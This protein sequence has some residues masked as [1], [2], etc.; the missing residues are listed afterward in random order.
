MIIYG[1]FQ[2]IPYLKEIFN[3]S[4]MYNYASSF[5]GNPNFY[6]SY[7][8]MST[9]LVTIL[10]IYNKKNIFIVAFF[11]FGLLLSGS[12]ACILA[13]ICIYI[14]FCIILLYRKQIK[15]YIIKMLAIILIF[16]F[17]FILVNDI[18]QNQ[19]LDDSKEATNQFTYSIN[20]GIKNEYGNNRI[21]IW[22]KTIEILPNNIINGVGIDNFENAFNPPLRTITDNLIVDKAHNEYL[23]KL[24][25]EG[26]F[27]FLTYVTLLLY[28]FC[29]S[30]IS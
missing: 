14:F 27:S 29:E 17:N 20:N 23:Q 18:T 3:I 22:K 26:I 12:L 8:L 7:I 28:I 6:G 24:I 13:F 2:V 1:I 4:S 21:Y 11:I 30:K 19:I 10:Y 15:K 9:C 16:T 5:L 25:T